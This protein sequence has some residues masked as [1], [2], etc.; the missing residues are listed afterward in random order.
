MD[1][2]TPLP[3]KNRYENEM[4]VFRD[5][6]RRS[7]ALRSV[8]A[9]LFLKSMNFPIVGVQVVVVVGAFEVDLGKRNQEGALAFHS[10]V[11][12]D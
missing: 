5:R 9:G 3:C 8:E 11:L 4:C 1:A 6:E 10:V 12:V 7:R 2:R